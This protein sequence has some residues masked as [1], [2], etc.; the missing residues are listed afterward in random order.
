ME[1]LKKFL[2][3]AVAVAVAVIVVAILDQGTVKN[4]MNV[5]VNWVATSMGLNE[6]NLFSAITAPVAG[7]LA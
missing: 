6:P 5:V 3:L 2:W 1:H 7:L 4:A